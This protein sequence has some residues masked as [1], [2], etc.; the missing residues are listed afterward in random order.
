MSPEL[1]VDLLRQVIEQSLLLVGPVLMTAMATGVFI[2]LMQSVTSI[3]E[4]TLTFVPK[5]LSVA[6]VFVVGAGWMVRSMIEFA[7]RIFSMV[8]S[9]PM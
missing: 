5:L 9:P 3:Q 6:G 2:S 8:G 7:T 4:P 1:A